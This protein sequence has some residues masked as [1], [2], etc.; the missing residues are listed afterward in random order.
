MNKQ[1][2]IEAITNE[3]LNGAKIAI[4]KLIKKALNSGAIDVEAWD[5]NNNP[6]LLPK[7][8]LIAALENEADQYKATNTSFEKKIKKEVNNLKLFL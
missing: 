2:Q 1:E 7:V 3:M 6:M 8:I 4:Q 5:E